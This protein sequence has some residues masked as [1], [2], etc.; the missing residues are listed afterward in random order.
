MRHATGR[1]SRELDLFR[2]IVDRWE[3]L[4][5]REIFAWVAHENLPPVAS[6]D[7]HRREHLASWK[8]LLP[9]PKRED[10]VVEYLRSTAPAYVT[11]FWPDL[12]L[13]ERAAA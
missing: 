7:F 1:L 9:C 10:A 4:N 13:V 8:T 6:G 12:D 3:L 5:R 2:D 11:P